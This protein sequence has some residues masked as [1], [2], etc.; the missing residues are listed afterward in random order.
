MLCQSQPLA[1]ALV[2]LCSLC[3]PG[4][5]VYPRLLNPHTT[6]VTPYALTLVLGAVAIAGCPCPLPSPSPLLRFPC[7]HLRV[8]RC[9]PQPLAFA[10]LGSV[11]AWLLMYLVLCLLSLTC[12]QY[13]THAT[14]CQ[15]FALIYALP[16]T[17]ATRH[18]VYHTLYRV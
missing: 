13:S 11:L 10:V 3:Y 18:R 15:V 4:Q 6:L 2:L 12:L 17:L 5:V 9:F 7:L 16:C 1:P 8:C 14:P